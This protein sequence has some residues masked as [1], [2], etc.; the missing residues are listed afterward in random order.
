MCLKGSPD[1]AAKCKDIAWI[2]PT[3]DVSFYKASEA[4]SVSCRSSLRDGEL[5]LWSDGTSTRWSM[6]ARFTS[7]V[8]QGRAQAEAG[9]QAGAQGP[10]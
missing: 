9:T 3:I 10:G 2:M 8:G 5:P 4:A 7:G 1:S 6:C